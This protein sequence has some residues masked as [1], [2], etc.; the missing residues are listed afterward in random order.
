MDVNG[1]ATDVPDTDPARAVTR[2]G[3]GPVPLAVL[4]HDPG[5]TEHRDLLEAAGSAARLA[6]ENA[7]L[8][9]QVRAQL[10]EMRASRGRLVQVADAERRRLERDLHDG[11]QQRLLGM[12]MT[13][14][15]LRGRVGADPATDRLIDE[16][17]GE[18]RAA[19]TEL[20]NLAQGIH[21]AVLTDQ[22]LLAA[23][24]MLAR[25]CPLPVDLQ[26]DLPARPPPNLEAVAYYLISE[27]LQNTVKHGHATGVLVRIQTDIDALVL[28]VID[29]GI[30]GADPGRGSGLHGLHD[31]LSAIDG[32]LTVHS[33]PG[34]GTH[35]H[36]RLPWT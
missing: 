24:G 7:R 10:A 3:E 14:H 18:L 33:P 19:L 35:L 16:V 13:L 31:R 22:G 28:D 4:V 1:H 11:A 32:T 8:H 17:A 36:A 20:R 9:A 26:G 12:G 27:A 2:L 15:A 25:R 34:G 5:L 21:P 6:L 23:L 29:D 30:G